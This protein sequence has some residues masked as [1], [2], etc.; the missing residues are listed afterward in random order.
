MDLPDRGPGAGPD[1]LD[2]QPGHDR[3]A[4][5]GRAMAADP[6][7]VARARSVT[8]MRAPPG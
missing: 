1:H 7:T 6:V 8:P 3:A 2:D 5:T 4:T